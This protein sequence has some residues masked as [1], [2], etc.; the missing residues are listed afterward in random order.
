M[1]SVAKSVH[2][3]RIVVGTAIVNPVGN[4]NLSPEEEKQARRDLVKKALDTLRSEIKS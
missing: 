1:V 2:A 3:N 4:P